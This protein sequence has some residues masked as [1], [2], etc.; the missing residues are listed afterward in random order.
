MPIVTLTSDF[1]LS[2]YYAAVVKGA[3]LSA[4]DQ[5]Q[6]IDITHNI[7]PFDIVQG[8]YILKNAY[9]SF[10]KGSIHIISVNNYSNKTHCLLAAR[11]GD[12]F[13]LG[14]DNGIFSLIFP[15]IPADIYELPYNETAS[16]P[17]KDVFAKAVNHIAGSLPFNEIGI[18]LEDIEQRI[19]IQPV[20]TNSSI[21]GSV[22][23]ID[24]YENVI[25][26][27][28]RELFER[29]WN[30]RKYMIYFKRNEPIK[31]IRQSYFDVPVGETLC[32]FNSAEYLEIAIN[33]GKAASM[34]SL[35]VDDHVQI[36]FQ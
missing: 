19:S 33:M 28:S 22:I 17:L 11:Y 16:F 9:R 12:H 1:G 2:D 5:L 23:H 34:H 35:R 21:R 10:P 27:I 3:I 26:N 30:K 14:P 29:V 6:I 8:A 7:K 18:P 32:L 24:N 20:I 4:N 36:D 13:F 25:V 31:K 15:K